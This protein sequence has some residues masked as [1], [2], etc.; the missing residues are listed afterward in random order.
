MGTVQADSGNERGSM[1][2]TWYVPT[3]TPD[4]QPA[5]SVGLVVRPAIYCL[6]LLA[7][8]PR[9]QPHHLAQSPLQRDASSHVSDLCNAGSLSELLG[10]LDDALFAYEQAIRANPGSIQAMNSISLILRTREE[11]PKAVNYL[12]NILKLDATNGEAWGS[13]GSYFSLMMLTT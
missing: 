13:L 6:S 7:S 12:D 3:S 10:N 11:F 9:Q 8:W 1:D 5:C 4:N 2:S